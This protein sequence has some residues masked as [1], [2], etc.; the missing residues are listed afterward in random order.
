MDMKQGAVEA[1]KVIAPFKELSTDALAELAPQV[2]IRNYPIGTYVFRRGDAGLGKL[3]VVVDGLAEVT[4]PDDKGVETV[5]GYR[6]R[7]DIFGETVVLTGGTYSGNVRVSE[8]LTCLLIPSTVFE[9]LIRN[10]PEVSAFFSRVMVDRMR[11]L[12]EEII[13]EQSLDLFTGA[14]RSLFKRRV[15]EIMSRPVVTCRSDD[16]VTGVAGLMAEHNISSVVVIDDVGQPLGLITEKD[17]VGQILAHGLDPGDRRA[18]DVMNTELVT[19]SSDAY[20]NEALLAVIRSG[21]KHVAVIESDLLVGMISLVDLLRARSSGTLW[22]AHRIE[23]EHTLAG[24]QEIGRE[25]DRFLYA[26]VAEKAPTREL[27]EIMTELNDKLTRQ[28]IRCCEQQMV[29]EGLGRPPVPYC[30]VSL[31]SAG[32]REQALRTDQDNAFIYADPEPD[33]AGAVREYFLKLGARIVDG[34]AACGF[35]NRT[36]EVVVSNP[37]W[38][39]SLSGWKKAL[40]NWVF[41]LEPEGI[42]RLAVFLDFRPVFGDRGLADQLWETVFKAFDKQTVAA[43]MLT[44]HE[45]EYRVPLTMLG[46]FITEKS[47]PHENQLNLKYS[48]ALHI[49]GCIRVFAMSAKINETSTFGR[50]E[51]LVEAGEISRDDAEFILASFETVTMFRIRENVIKHRQ[52]LPADDYITPSELSKRERAILRDAVSVISRL[53]KLTSTKFTEEWFGFLRP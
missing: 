45:V 30:F 16:V 4:V 37:V 14:E 43:H 52:G 44:S 10:Y 18:G 35:E 20:L 7:N 49:V 46:G 38:C 1:L 36:G 23:S 11:M 25:V 51:R 50:L 28:V 24:L 13:T 42:R 22:V 34:L 27:L 2:E 31:G 41:N 47:G 29:S 5:V 33:Q 53:Q 32:R 40:H 19:L 26:L 17:L 6:R 12:Y 3:F 8:E 15:S 21:A 9:N 39:R 48:V